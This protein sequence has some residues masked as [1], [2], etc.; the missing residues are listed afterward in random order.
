MRRGRSRGVE[1][2]DFVAWHRNKHH[3][4]KLTLGDEVP[5]KDFAAFMKLS[6]KKAS[7]A[8]VTGEKLTEFFRVCDRL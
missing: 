8:F 6:E 3:I 1:A 2:S 7:S 4:E 5:R